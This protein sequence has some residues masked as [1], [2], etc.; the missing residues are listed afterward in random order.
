MAGKVFR[1]GEAHRSRDIDCPGAKSVDDLLR[2]QIDTRT[3][4]MATLESGE[5]ESGFPHRLGRDCARGQRSAQ[6]RR[7]VHDRNALA[8]IGSLRSGLLARR[9][10]AYH[11]HFEVFLHRSV[12]L[13]L[14]VRP[15]P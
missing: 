7:V 5:V 12:R 11:D 1:N 6:R 8:E 4:D 2:M 10:S 15:P 14:D 13:G 9:A 3:V